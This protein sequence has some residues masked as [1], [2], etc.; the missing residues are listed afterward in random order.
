MTAQI[1]EY[2]LLQTEKLCAVIDRAYSCE[3]IYGA[4]RLGQQA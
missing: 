1:P 4:F 2:A 3:V